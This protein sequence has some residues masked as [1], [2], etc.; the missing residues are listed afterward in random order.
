MG[1]RLPF[2]FGFHKNEHLVEILPNIRKIFGHIINYLSTLLVWCVLVKYPTSIFLHAPALTLSAFTF[3][4]LHLYPFHFPPLTPLSLSPSSAY[5]CATKTILNLI[6][7]E[8]QFLLTFGTYQKVTRNTN[9]QRKW[10]RTRKEK[11]RRTKT[12]WWNEAI[13]RDGKWKQSKKERTGCGRKFLEFIKKESAGNLI[14]LS[15]CRNRRNDWQCFGWCN[16]VKA[17]FHSALFV[18]KCRAREGSIV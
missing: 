7:I 11:L 16:K 17:D 15:T 1:K 13:K 10:W 14:S 4:R 2:W 8:K 12:R 9:S 5:N 3:L 18:V 6:W